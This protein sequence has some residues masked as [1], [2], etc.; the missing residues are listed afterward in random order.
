MHNVYATIHAY[1]AYFTPG[2]PKTFSWFLRLLLL[3]ERNI[4]TR[5][6]PGVAFASPSQPAVTPCSSAEAP[7]IHFHDG[8]LG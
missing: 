5:S 3:E 4:Y 7:A 1:R 2:R 6:I 8:G